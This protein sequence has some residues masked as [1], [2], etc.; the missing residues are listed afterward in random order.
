MS[1]L[2]IRICGRIGRSSFLRNKSFIIKPIDAKHG[3]A[4]QRIAVAV[5]PKNMSQL[6]SLGLGL[7]CDERQLMLAGRRAVT[8]ERCFNVREGARREDDVLPWRMMNEEVPD[9]ANAGMVTDKKMLDGLLDQYYALH[10]WDVETA[11]PL[12]STLEQLGL[13]AVCGD[14][15]LEG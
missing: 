14:V 13:S 7:P 12:G 1:I 9:G 4:V 2:I 6:V 10:G 5:N 15:S 8:I 11:V 3:V